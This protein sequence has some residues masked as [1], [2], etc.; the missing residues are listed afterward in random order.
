MRIDLT[1]KISK[2]KFQEMLKKSSAQLFGHFGT[3]FDVMDKEFPLDFCRREGILLDASAVENRDYDLSDVDLS[4][5]KPDSFVIV[6]TGSIEKFEYGSDEYIKDVRRFSWDLIRALVDKKISIIGIDCSGL[7]PTG[8]EHHEADQFCADHGIFVV[9]NLVNL[10]EL[11]N[12]NQSF[13]VN[14]YPMNL[15]GYTGIPSRVIAEI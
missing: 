11:Q 15:E 3:H 9:E 12:Q 4:I 5:V 7:R 2:S 1:F 6:R 14:T 10:A 13:I 8:K